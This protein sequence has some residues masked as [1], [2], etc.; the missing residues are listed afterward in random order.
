MVSAGLLP[1]ICRAHVYVS[2]A[3]D[4][5][6]GEIVAPFDPLPS[7]Q[8]VE[9]CSQDDD[10]SAEDLDAWLSRLFNLQ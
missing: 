10:T 3:S 7:T 2:R 5:F 6:S 1:P 8:R 9:E 4:Y